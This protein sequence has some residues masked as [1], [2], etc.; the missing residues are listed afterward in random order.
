[1]TMHSPARVSRRSVRPWCPHST[2]MGRSLRGDLPFRAALV[3]YRPVSGAF[4]PP[5][6]VLCTFRSRYWCAIGLGTY[7]ALEAD[8]PQLPAPY[9]RYGTLGSAHLLASLRL[10]GCHPLWRAIPGRFGSAG[11]GGRPAHNPTSPHGF[12]YGFG[13]GSS[14]FPRRYSGNP[15]LV[16]SPPPTWMLP[17]GGFPLPGLNPGARAGAEAP[18]P[19]RSH[20]GIPGST[21]ACG[22]PGLFAACRALLRRPSRGIH[23]PASSGLGVFTPPS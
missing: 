22:Y 19:R 21:P 10:R 16:S 5:P 18:T 17:F 8:G 15:I 11:R 12:P 13:L 4:H 9:P 20:S 7:L 2:P 14:L 6:G 1:M 3:C 23:R